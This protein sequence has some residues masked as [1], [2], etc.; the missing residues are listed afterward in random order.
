MNYQFKAAQTTFELKATCIEKGVFF[1]YDKEKKTLH[2]KFRVSLKTNLGRTSFMFYG[3]QND[4]TNG[5][6]ALSESDAKHALYCFVSDAICGDG[7]FEDF[8]SELGYDSISAYKGCVK[9]L[10]KLEKIINDD[11]Y[12]I[13][14]NLND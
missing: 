14:N 7:S 13:L 9:S 8:C 12:D 4:N 11:I 10:E 6:T 1:P 5:I 2:N 3:S